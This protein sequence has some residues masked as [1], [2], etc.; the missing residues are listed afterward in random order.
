MMIVFDLRSETPTFVVDNDDDEDRFV[1]L[2]NDD[3][4]LIYYF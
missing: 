1:R 2:F 3:N 4:F